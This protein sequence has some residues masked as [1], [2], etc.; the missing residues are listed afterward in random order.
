ME[1]HHQH[2]YTYPQKHKHYAD[3]WEEHAQ[4][5]GDS[6]GQQSYGHWDEEHDTEKQSGSYDGFHRF[7]FSW[8]LTSRV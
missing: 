4:Q 3:P 6:K 1:D 8:V 2:A 5:Y 7:P